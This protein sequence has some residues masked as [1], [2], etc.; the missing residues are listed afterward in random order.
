MARICREAGAR[1]RTNVQLRNMN[2]TVP[3]DDD[4]Q[5]EVLA[6]GLPIYNGAQLAVDVTLCSALRADGS[7]RPRAHWQDGAAI[8]DA[9]DDKEERYSELTRGERC[10]LK[11]IALE[12]GGRMSMETL[13]FLTDLSFAKARTAPAYLRKAIQFAFLRR[14]TRMLA[15]SVAAVF[16]ASLL[17]DSET[18]QLLETSDGA[19]PWLGDLLS[20]ARHDDPIGPSRL[21]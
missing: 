4:R 15:V 8:E 12:S 14:W 21:R 10:R 5:I 13:Q 7:A 6:S 2:V 9:V 19:A 18:L 20:E 17:E 3:C 16:T 1:V 11:V